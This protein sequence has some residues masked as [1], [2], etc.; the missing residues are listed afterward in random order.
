VPNA[1]ASDAVHTL[2]RPFRSAPVSAAA[3]SRA[4]LPRRL[5]SPLARRASRRA[6]PRASSRAAL[7][8]PR[9]AASREA[10][11]A[12]AAPP[13]LAASRA[14]AWSLA[15]AASRAAAQAEHREPS[16]ASCTLQPRRVRTPLVARIAAPQ[17][18]EPRAALAER[19]RVPS[20]LRR[21]LPASR[22]ASRAEPSVERRAECARPRAELRESLQIL[23]LLQRRSLRSRSSPRSPRYSLAA[24]MPAERRSRVERRSSPAELA[25]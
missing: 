11:R 1:T 3:P 17:P 18:S 7:G 4:G 13:P 5:T 19:S 23:S 21:P 15:A 6:P 24:A 25:E 20:A 14:E 8:E 9:G 10:E 2:S 22:A 16:R 12:A